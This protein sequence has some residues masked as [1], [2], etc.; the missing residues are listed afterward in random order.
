MLPNQQIRKWNHQSII[1]QNDTSLY[2]LQAQIGRGNYS[3]VRR[4]Y[5]RLTKGK[6]INSIRFEPLL[7]TDW[8]LI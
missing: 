2:K 4:G 5:H 7:K 1:R 6:L 3:I 8:K